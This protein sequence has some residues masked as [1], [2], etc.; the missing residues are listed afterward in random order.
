MKRRYLIGLAGASALVTACGDRPIK[1]SDSSRSSA[2]TSNLVTLKVDWLKSIAQTTPLL[3]GSNDYEITDL[4]KASDRVFQK[5]LSELNIGLIRIHHK[6]LSDRWTN[7]TKKT[8]DENK[9]KAVFDVSYPHKPTIVQNIPSW[10]KW[11]TQ[12]KNGLLAPSE[13][14]RY[15]DF[16]ADLVTILNQRQHRNILYWEPFNEQ[17]KAYQQAGK[18]DQLWQIYN[19]AAVAMK[20]RDSRLKIGGPVL[21][22]DNDSVL[23]GFLDR[24]GANIDFISWHRYASGDAKESTE[25]ILAYPR[26]FSDQVGRFRN[27]AAKHV[28]SRQVPL[29]LSEYNINFTWDSGE[30]RQNTHIGAVW[31]AS[32]F[33]H[34]AESGI[35]MAASWHLKDGI[36]GIIDPENKLRP[37]AHVFAWGNQYLIGKVVTT[38]SDRS[39]L[40]ALAVSQ[41][42]GGRSLLLINKSASSTNVKLQNEELSAKKVFSYDLDESG[43]NNKVL[44][45]LDEPLI[46]KPHSLKLLR[47]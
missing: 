12:D 18:L 1:L 44:S 3:F 11:M 38:Q 8:W 4:N 33:K 39:S 20:N 14:D 7:A 6:E 10:P 27:L 21:T 19:K 2:T 16:C 26:E 46:M 15:A 28:R 32:A 30:T 40:E 22:W 17:E 45:K 36:Y 37:A 13:F 41:Q 9:I 47:F 31:F 34:L 35:D 25:K 23:D 5:Q 43:V 29:F 42:N 24:C